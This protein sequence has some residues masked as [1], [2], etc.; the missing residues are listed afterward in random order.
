MRFLIDEQ[1]P[2]AL[3]KL[4]SDNGHLAQHV[5]DAGLAGQSDEIVWRR[6]GAINA[7]IITKDADF[8]IR[9]ALDPT[10]P[11]VVWLRLS[12]TR[13]PALLTAMLRALPR[14]VA[15]LESGARLVQISRNEES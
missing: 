4:L 3:A 14:V 1:L 15:A 8:V 5:R 10:G 7:V 9:Q 6:A 11:A 13:R 12:N 2:P